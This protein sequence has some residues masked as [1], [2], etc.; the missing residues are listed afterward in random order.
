MTLKPRKRPSDDYKAIPYTFQKLQTPLSQ[1]PELVVNTVFNWYKKSPNLFQYRGARLVTIT[2]P[3]FDERLEQRL[4]QLVQ[5]KYDEELDFVISIMKDYKGKTILHKICRE[6]IIVV[7]GQGHFCREVEIVLQEAGVLH[8]EFGFVTMCKQ[9]KEEI[10][11]WL[12]DPEQVVRE[13]A[14]KYIRML[15]REQASEQRRAEEELEL[16]KHI[17]N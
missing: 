8:G 15:D 17:Y 5:T 6:L 3:E 16:R 13:F 7:E 10:K 4:L 2:F 14:N 1:Y 9:K 11:Y 12:D